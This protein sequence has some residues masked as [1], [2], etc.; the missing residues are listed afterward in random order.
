MKCL[1]FL[2]LLAL[3]A[4]AQLENQ[5]LTFSE[6]EKLWNIEPFDSAKFKTSRQED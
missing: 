2:F 6:A 4:L 3:P 1:A 5:F